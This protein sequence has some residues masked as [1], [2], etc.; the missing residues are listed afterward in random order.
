MQ[1][2]NPILITIDVEECDILLEYGFPIDL[3][4]Q[5]RVSK[6]G[7]DRFMDLVDSLEIPVTIFVRVF[8][9]KIIRSGLN[10][11]IRGMNWH[12]MDFTMENLRQ[13][14]ICWIQKRYYR[15]CRVKRLRVFGWRGCSRWM[16]W[17]F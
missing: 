11:Y 5:L 1:R 10:R 14:R 17:R 6:E 9:R 2:K 8:L 3:N 15:N 7:L 13:R 4:E 12:H 16:K